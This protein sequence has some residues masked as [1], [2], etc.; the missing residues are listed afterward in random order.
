V[1]WTGWTGGEKK[2]AALLALYYGC[3]PGTDKI[4]IAINPAQ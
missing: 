2:T 1:E 4:L 3:V